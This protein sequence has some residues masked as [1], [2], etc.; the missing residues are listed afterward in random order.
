M[1]FSSNSQMDKRKKADMI[2]IP[3]WKAKKGSEW[4]VKSD[5]ISSPS[6]A[7]LLK[8]GD[9]KGKE[10]E[11]FYLYDDK[12]PEKQMILLGLGSK[13]KLSM[14]SLRRAYGSL[15]KFCLSRNS[16]SLNLVL[17]E[18]KDLKREDLLVRLRKVFCFPI[19]YLTSTSKLYRTKKKKPALCKKFAGSELP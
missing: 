4:A 8:S 7:L 10:G 16:T 1:D 19:T 2:A 18:T 14:E 6:I 17:P 5:S 11:V 13:E 9:F 3:F 12:V 15:T